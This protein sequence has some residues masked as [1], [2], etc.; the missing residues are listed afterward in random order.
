MGSKIC[1]MSYNRL[2]ISPEYQNLQVTT[3]PIFYISDI[4][5]TD[6]GYIRP[7]ILY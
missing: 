6:A 4:L 7:E 5:S 2:Q 1:Q 3:K